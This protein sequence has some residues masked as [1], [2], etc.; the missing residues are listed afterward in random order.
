MF[1]EKPLAPV[2]EEAEHVVETCEAAGVD[3]GVTMPLRFSRLA[4]NVKKRLVAGELGEVCAIS[5]TNRGKMPGG[6][7]AD[8]EA[9]G[10][11]VMDPTVHIADP[12]H[13]LTGERV[14]EVY[15]ETAMRMHD[16]SVEDVNVF[17]VELT[18]ET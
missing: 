2:V 8:P 13:W 6:W 17:S 3:L 5:R 1:C 4:R 16:L 9:S 7:F 11:A 12:V 14:S 18:D 15:A 10:G